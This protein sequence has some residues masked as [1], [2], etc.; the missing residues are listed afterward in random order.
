MERLYH[1]RTIFLCDPLCPLWLKILEQFRSGILGVELG[2]FAQELFCPFIARHRNCHLN[3]DNLVSAMAFFGRRW[4]ALFPQPEFLAGLRS[5]RDFELRPAINRWHFDFCSQRGFGCGDRDCDVD[6]ITLAMEHGMVTGAD[7]DIEVSGWAAVQPGIALTRNSNALSIAGACLDS[8]FKGLGALDCP[9]AMADRAGGNVFSGAVAAR[10]SHVELHAST[11]L[12]DRPLALTLRTYARGFDIAISVTIAA[13]IAAGEIQPHDASADRRPERHVHLVFE[14]GT[15]LRAFLRGGAAASAENSGEDVAETSRASTSSPAPS[16]FEQ[17]GE[18]EPSEV[19]VRA[20]TA[21]SGL[22]VGKPSESTGAGWAATRISLSRRWIN[23]VRVEA[24]LV[25]NLALLGIA[26]Y[27]VSFGEGLKFFFGSFV[28]G[29]DVR[30]IF[31]RKL[32]EC[33]ADVLGGGGLFYAEDFVIVFLGGGCH[34]CRSLDY[35]SLPDTRLASLIAAL[36]AALPY[37]AVR[38][39]TAT[40]LTSSRALILAHR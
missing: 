4:H 37:I 30:M 5:R 29:I 31:A 6:V 28:S 1:N 32:A 17:I 36:A 33:L 13:D 18:I 14:V 10:A 15:R 22:A 27:V 35:L 2:Q 7:N 24:E 12:F 34:L 21:G 19:E 8:H 23:I 16:S 3:F 38:A 40:R 39:C 11:G 25:V 9:F 26:E 20:L